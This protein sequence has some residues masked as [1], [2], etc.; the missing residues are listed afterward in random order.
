MSLLDSMYT[1]PASDEV[2]ELEAALQEAYEAGISDGYDYALNEIG[3]TPRGMGAIDAVIKRNQNRIKNFDFNIKPTY[4]PNA[5]SGLASNFVNI[6]KDIHS[7]M[8]NKQKE[9]QKLL[10]KDYKFKNYKM[11]AQF[12]N[13]QRSKWQ[14]R[15]SKLSPDVRAKMAKIANL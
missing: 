1:P 5:K 8:M 14:D 3:D 10:D 13:E 12:R 6:N 15:L 2:D 11:N 4:T 9:H 7:Q